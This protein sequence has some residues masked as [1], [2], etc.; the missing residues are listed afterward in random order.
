MNRKE[1]RARWNEIQHKK[2]EGKD[3]LGQTAIVPPVIVIKSYYQ[4][5][6]NF[7]NSNKVIIAISLIIGISG[8]TFAL[9]DHFFPKGESD[10]AKR[11]ISKSATIEVCSSS[12]IGSDTR[13]NPGLIYKQDSSLI[14]SL[15]ICNRGQATATNFTDSSYVLTGDIPDRNVGISPLVT[16]IFDEH[17]VIPG[18]EGKT[19]RIHLSKKD[20]ACF[21]TYKYTWIAIRI[22]YTDESKQ[23]G[24][25]QQVFDLTNFNP[26]DPIPAANRIA[27]EKLEGILKD[28]NLW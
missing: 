22:H 3:D 16:D 13:F 4:R 5:V 14:F 17:M 25:F 23:K 21:K 26:Y 24:M 11:F 28:A 2:K 7:I 18:L 27:T 6:L 19:M 1:R 10:F 8:G 9:W 15:A 20:V 12:G